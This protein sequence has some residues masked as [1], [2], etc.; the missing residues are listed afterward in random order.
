MEGFINLLIILFIF[1][2]IGRVIKKNRQRQQK[3]AGEQNISHQITPTQYRTHQPKSPSAPLDVP[4]GIK[5][6]GTPLKPQ[7]IHE[8]KKV[9]DMP[10]NL[11]R[12]P[13]CGGEI[14]LSMMKCDIC[15]ARQ[16]GCSAFML[17]LVICAAGII[18]ALITSS[19]A[20]MAG[21]FS[22]IEQFFIK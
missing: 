10:A 17:L 3:E 11:K 21:F 8:Y 13:K 20:S 14:P 22:R 12:C 16:P 19:D 15:G 5:P 6:S 1:N 7:V 9:K 2:L 4:A 18:I